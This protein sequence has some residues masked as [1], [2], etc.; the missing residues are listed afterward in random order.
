MEIGNLNISVE[1][2]MPSALRRLKELYEARH[3]R[4]R[5]KSKLKRS[6]VLLGLVSWILGYPEM[7][8][9]S[10]QAI[11]NYLNS[12][13]MGAFI[14]GP[15]NA[16]FEIAGVVSAIQQEFREK[17]DSATLLV[18]ARYYDSKNPVVRAFMSKMI[19]GVP[20]FRE[21]ERERLFGKKPGKRGKKL[22]SIMMDVLASAL[23]HGIPV[24]QYL[25][26]IRYG[27]KT[28]QKMM[29]SLGTEYE[30]NPMFSHPDRYIMKP[31]KSGPL[32]LMNRMDDG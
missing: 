21:E 7:I 28:H 17:V 15:H 27:T 14:A 8:D 26:G 25:S 19:A 13:H 10:E 20:S 31:G 32:L 2:E 11:K 4:N 9:D 30:A 18:A 22:I 24:G 16:A 5:L 3:D 12:K 6:K 29:E 23:K 1:N